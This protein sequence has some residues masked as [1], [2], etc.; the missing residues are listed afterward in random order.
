MKGAQRGIQKETK[1][2]INVVTAHHLDDAT[3]TYLMSFLKSGINHT[4]VIPYTR[5]E[6]HTVRPFLLNKKAEMRAYCTKWSIP[7]LDDPMNELGNCSRSIIR[8]QLLPLALSVNPGLYKQ[9]A[10]IIREEQS[11]SHSD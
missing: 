6:P 11:C 2:L 9:V 7:F 10:N 5:R 4:K 8:Y 3:E 1:E